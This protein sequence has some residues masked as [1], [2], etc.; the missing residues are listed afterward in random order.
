M[1]WLKI[2]YKCNL[3][4]LRK[5]WR[6]SIYSVANIWLKIWD[7]LSTFRPQTSTTCF[8]QI[9][10]CKVKGKSKEQGGGS[11][12]RMETPYPQEG[13][14]A[15]SLLSPQLCPQLVNPFPPRRTGL[16]WPCTEGRAPDLHASPHPVEEEK[17][18]Q[19]QHTSLPLADTSTQRSL[20][21]E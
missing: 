9:N 21:S 18:R 4:L 10:M 12:G 15:E 16:S 8:Y 17:G 14:G 7:T 6:Y 11:D 19:D 20:R 2:H 13:G 5:I 3:S 1:F